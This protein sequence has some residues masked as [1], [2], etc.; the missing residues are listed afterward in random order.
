MYKQFKKF[1]A[2]KISDF[3]RI[4]RKA[5][6]EI[7]LEDLQNNAWI[8]AADLG[9]K[10][11]AEIDFGSEEDR[12]WVLA[13][14][15]NQSVRNSKSV[16]YAVSID[17]APNGNDDGFPTLAETLPASE[18]SD[19][20]QALLH[21]EKS[22]QAAKASELAI[23]S[24]YSQAAAY[25]ISLGQFNDAESLS[26][27]LAISKGT[28]TQRISRAT[29]S[30]KIQDS[31]FDGIERI[32]RSFMPKKGIPRSEIN[33][34]ASTSDQLTLPLPECTWNLNAGQP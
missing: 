12:N 28:L 33:L 15:Y 6:G 1:L 11:K 30:L 14:L 24:T 25:I 26:I 7:E 3:R 8:V 19:P 18:N 16:R 4:V 31:L 29:L 10:R 13:T 23:A 20:L 5:R 27:F 34:F 32:S 22:E 21:L 2:E 17:S 9:E